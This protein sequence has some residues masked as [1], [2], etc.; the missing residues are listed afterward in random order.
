MSHANTRQSTKWDQLSSKSDSALVEVLRKSEDKEEENLALQILQDRYQPKLE[1]LLRRELP[2]DWVDE[3][4][5]EIWIGFYNYV[6]VK[7]VY[8]GVPNLLWGIARN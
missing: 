4:A 6:C 3:I 1:R 7:E 5:Q 2:S 8:K